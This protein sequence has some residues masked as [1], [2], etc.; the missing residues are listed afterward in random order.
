MLLFLFQ[1]IAIIDVIVIIVVYWVYCYYWCYC[2]YWTYL[3][4]Q[5]GWI[6]L[7]HESY[8]SS[9][10]GTRFS[11]SYQFRVSSVNCLLYQLATQGQFH[12]TCAA[13]FP[14]RPATAGRVP[15]MDAGCGL[16]TRGH[17]DGPVIYNEA[18][19]AVWA[20]VVPR[21]ERFHVNTLKHHVWGTL[22]PAL[23]D[24]CQF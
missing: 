6:R 2:N 11:T 7:V 10:T 12:T 21:G 24:L 17:W 23:M 13:T 15:A 16:S 8:M 22:L 5:V 1:F 14:G 9:T 19:R 4:I 3:F 20:S 18:G